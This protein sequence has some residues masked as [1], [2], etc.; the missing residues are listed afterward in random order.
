MR[1]YIPKDPVVLG[2]LRRLN[3]VMP[4]VGI[5]LFGLVGA[6]YM[7]RLHSFERTIATI[8][9][10]WDAEQYGHG[11]KYTFTFG[12]LSFTRVAPDGQNHACR[13]PFR[14]GRPYDQFRV[15]EKLE[16]IPATG[17]CQRVDVIGRAVASSK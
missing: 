1:S 12:L 9:A 5:V 15:G 11:E 7:W 3:I 14:I 17:T 4:L 8:E 16:I 10:V 13:H 2:Q 6:V